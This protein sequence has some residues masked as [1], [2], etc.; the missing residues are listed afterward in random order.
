[1]HFLHTETIVGLSPTATTKNIAP[2]DRRRLAYEAEMR[3]IVTTQG[4]QNLLHAGMNCY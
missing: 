3:W 2:A 1:M 4:L